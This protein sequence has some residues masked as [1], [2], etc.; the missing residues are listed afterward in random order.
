MV[1]G[2]NCKNPQGEK[3]KNIGLLISTMKSNGAE[4][5]VSHLSHLLEKE[6]KVHLILF[7]DTYMEYEV[8]G[9]L[10]NLNVPAQSGSPIVKIGLLE[11]RV[12]VLKK[13]IK[14][15][16]IEC[17]VSFLDSPNFVNLLARVKGCRKII[18]IRN[19]SGLEN[20]Q[21]SI[22]KL[23]DVIMKHLYRRAD[24]VVTVSK[25]IEEDFRQHYNIPKAK[26]KTI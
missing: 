11:K 2:Q 20:Q 10:H 25:L 9:T 17:V 18:S 23:T 22:M 5:V 3:M 19:Y 13:L 1:N 24:C 7:E 4:R 8:G 21:N 6:Y 26:I 15:E 12:R 14:K 16:N